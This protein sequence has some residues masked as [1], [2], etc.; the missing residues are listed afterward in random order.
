M[1][2]KFDSI[3][4]PNLLTIVLIGNNPVRDPPCHGL[5]INMEL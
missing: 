2:E 5:D 4:N 1:S 3:G